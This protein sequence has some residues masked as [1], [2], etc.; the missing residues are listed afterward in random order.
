MGSP[1][2]YG[3]NLSTQGRDLFDP[4]KFAIRTLNHINPPYKAQIG[5]IVMRPCGFNQGASSFKKE[6]K[7]SE[8]K[9]GLG[10]N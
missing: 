8:I 3:R 5:V 4:A 7:I 9:G 2:N 10:R 1:K 6:G